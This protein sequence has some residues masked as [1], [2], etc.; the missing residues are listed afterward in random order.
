MP[1][2]RRTAR[3]TVSAE[4]FSDRV[5]VASFVADFVAEIAADD[6]ALRDEAGVARVLAT[7]PPLPSMQLRQP[8]RMRAGAGRAAPRY[9]RQ[10]RASGR[11]GMEHFGSPCQL[12]EHIVAAARSERCQRRGAF[13]A[14]SGS[15]KLQDPRNR[16]GHSVGKRRLK[17]GR[18]ACLGIPADAVRPLWIEQDHPLVSSNA[19]SAIAGSFQALRPDQTVLSAVRRVGVNV[20]PP[21]PLP[22]LTRGAFCAMPVG[23]SPTTLTKRSKHSSL[24]WFAG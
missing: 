10:H 9:A 12:S 1:G 3:L 14:R 5:I 6:G 18:V 16:Q 4:H 8:A 24:F 2:E 7:R 21:A 20:G 19:L 17:L 23:T 13:P 15:T 11:M 22:P